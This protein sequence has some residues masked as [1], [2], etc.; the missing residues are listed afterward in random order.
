MLITFSL[1]LKTSS[2]NSSA[3]TAS[4]SA[5]SIL[6]QTSFTVAQMEEAT[7]GFAAKNLLGKGGFGSVYRGMLYGTPVA[8]KKLHDGGNI[9]EFELEVKDQNA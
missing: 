1:L 8:V 3:S 2:R 9:D 7:E 4:S 5:H 6:E